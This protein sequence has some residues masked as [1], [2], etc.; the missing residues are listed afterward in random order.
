MWVSDICQDK[1]AATIM[2]EIYLRVRVGWFTK[3][4]T[5]PLDE[6]WA[7]SGTSQSECH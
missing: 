7:V 2:D 4:E 6:G 5:I 3:T 1:G